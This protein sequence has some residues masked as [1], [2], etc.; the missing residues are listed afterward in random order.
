M[1]TKFKLFKEMLER[2]QLSNQ[3]FLLALEGLLESMLENP[4]FEMKVINTIFETNE[5]K[6]IALSAR[7]FGDKYPERYFKYIDNC[8]DRLDYILTLFENWPKFDIRDY[9]EEIIENGNTKTVV[10]YA[11]LLKKSSYPETLIISDF[12]QIFT[13]RPDAIPL[14]NHYYFSYRAINAMSYQEVADGLLDASLLSY[15]VTN[16]KVNGV[17]D[18]VIFYHLLNAHNGLKQTSRKSLR[19][20]ILKLSQAKREELS[21]EEFKDIVEISETIGLASFIL[22][23]QDRDNTSLLLKRRILNCLIKYY[24]EA[25]QLLQVYFVFLDGVVTNEKCLELDKEYKELIGIDTN[26]EEEIGPAIKVP[27]KVYQKL[28]TKKVDN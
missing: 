16:S 20:I 7:F 17:K 4:N 27:Y 12:E 19:D 9:A 1:L 2:K 23:F 14:F 26:Q 13:V 3:N 6:Y 10:R 18:L 22:T 11:V 5:I 28:I 15:Y 24:Q 8:K 21:Y 25:E